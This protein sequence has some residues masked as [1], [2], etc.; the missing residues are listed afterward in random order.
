MRR[1]TAS[2]DTH[3]RCALC[4]MTA[5]Q[6]HEHELYGWLLRQSGSLVDTYVL[7]QETSLRAMRQQGTFCVIE[8]A[9]ARPAHSG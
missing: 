8:N 6:P 2:S 4:L 1:G 9:S 3:E 7:L 5:W